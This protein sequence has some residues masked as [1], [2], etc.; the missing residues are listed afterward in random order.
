MLREEYAAGRLSV[1]LLE[2]ETERALR[3]EAGAAAALELR[4]ASPVAPDPLERYR[5]VI[6]RDAGAA[7][8][9]WAEMETRARLSG[10]FRRDLEL[11]SE[12]TTDPSRIKPRRRK[13]K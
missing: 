1:G 13:T 9:R 6:K 8:Q 7:A 5:V 2:L 10:D 12:P 11:P 4:P 3:S